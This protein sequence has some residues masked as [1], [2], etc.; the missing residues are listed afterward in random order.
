MGRARPEHEFR[1]QAVATF[2]EVTAIGHLRDHVGGTQR[3]TQLDALIGTCV[4][5]LE[6][7]GNR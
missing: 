7:A 1:I 6:G 2:L 4:P 5:I 3:V